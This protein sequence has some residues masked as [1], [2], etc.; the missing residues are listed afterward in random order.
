MTVKELI[1]FLKTQPQH[2]PVAYKC[3]SEQKLLEEWEV[4]IEDLCEPRPDGWVQNKRPDMK[5]TQYFVL[6]GN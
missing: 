4:G 5:T 3:W 2:L 6:P 1:D